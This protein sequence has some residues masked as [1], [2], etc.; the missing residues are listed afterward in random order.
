MF[1]DLCLEGADSRHDKGQL[2]GKG[3]MQTD[4]IADLLTSIRNALRA[5]K[6]AVY[7]PPRLKKKPSFKK[8]LNGT[9]LKTDMSNLIL[10]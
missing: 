9:P 2:V 3:I 7:V 1:A 8:F 6:G 5:R 10:L 4:P